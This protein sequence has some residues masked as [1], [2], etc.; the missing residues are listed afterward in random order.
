[1]P[2]Y[3]T[4]IYSGKIT[5]AMVIEG[6]ATPPHMRGELTHMITRAVL[7]LE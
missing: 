1:M 4:T 6:G 5:V 3:V 7:V 2:E